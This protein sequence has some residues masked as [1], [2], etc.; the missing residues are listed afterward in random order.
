MYTEPRQVEESSR[1][2]LARSRPRRGK[3][4]LF[5][6]AVAWLCNRR[7]DFWF[8]TTAQCLGFCQLPRSLF[9][10]SVL[11]NVAAALISPNVVSL[12]LHGPL[13]R[14]ADY[15][16]KWISAAKCAQSHS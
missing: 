12:E 14:F 11:L 3:R 2:E 10:G 7:A 15:S 1:F 5:L 8:G 6:Y 4:L 16:L 9:R 13:R